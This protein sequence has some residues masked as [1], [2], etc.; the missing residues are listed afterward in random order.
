MPTLNIPELIVTAPV[1]VFVPD[2]V[3]VPEP[4]F[5]MPE[6]PDSAIAQEII[7]DPPE[8]T[9]YVPFPVTVKLKFAEPPFCGWNVTEPDVALFVNDHPDPKVITLAVL[10]PFPINAVFVVLKLL[11]NVNPLKVKAADNVPD[12]G[13]F[14]IELSI[15]T[16][17]VAEAG[18]PSGFQ[19]VEVPQAVPA[20]DVP[21]S[22]FVCPQLKLV[23]NVPK[24]KIAVANS[25]CVIFCF[26][27]KLLLNVGL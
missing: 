20:P 17:V 18:T 23:A 26:I 4:D 11:L 10:P 13:W 19:F 22:H 16:S 2:N 21:P 25:R 5:V 12:V 24:Q 7:V 8:A 14:T 9:V 15:K 27:I 3:N 6:V 1:K